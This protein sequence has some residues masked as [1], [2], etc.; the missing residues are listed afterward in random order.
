MVI[1]DEITTYLYM[2]RCEDNGLY[3]GISTK[4]EQ[5]IANH[6]LGSGARYTK[7]NPPTKLV[8]VRK[9]NSR[10]DALRTE[11]KYKTYTRARK[12]KLIAEFQKEFD[13]FELDLQ[14]LITKL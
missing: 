5:R 14:T 11:K 12:E 1:T 13:N 8:Y 3:I 10:I 9:F 2:L 7:K 4:L 6:M